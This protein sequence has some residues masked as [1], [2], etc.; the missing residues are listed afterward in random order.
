[1]ILIIVFILFILF[2]FLFFSSLRYLSAL[3]LHFSFRFFY[4]DFGTPFETA[5]SKQFSISL[6]SVSK[7]PRLLVKFVYPNALSSRCMCGRFSSVTRSIT[8][9]Y[10]SFA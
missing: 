5:F 8:P 3:S 2:F 10:F 9:R 4:L 6:K 1:M 7:I